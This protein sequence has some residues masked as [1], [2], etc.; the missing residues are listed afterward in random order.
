LT[1]QGTW[2]ANAIETIMTANATV[3]PPSDILL[4]SEPAN[5]NTKFLWYQPAIEKYG[6]GINLLTLTHDFGTVCTHYQ[7]R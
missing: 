3:F 4:F 5:V 2:A 1:T 7:I 6:S